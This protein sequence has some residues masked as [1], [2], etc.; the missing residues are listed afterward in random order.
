MDWKSNSLPTWGC[1]IV[2]VVAVILSI[3]WRLQDKGAAMTWTQYLPTFL[4]AA[5]LIV[6]GILHFIALRTSQADAG[7]QPSGQWKP[8]WQKLQWA[9]AERERLEGEVRKWK[10][11]YTAENIATKADTSL[12]ARTIAMCDE[13]HHFLKDHGPEPSP[14]RDPVESDTEYLVR[15]RAIKTPWQERLTADYKIK[16]SS[17][18]PRIRDEIRLHSGMSELGLDQAIERAESYYTNPEAV[19]DICKHLWRLAY[20]M[21]G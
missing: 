7:T 3:V 6:A 4:I 9:N 21:T 17:S 12:R 13:L 16:F 19:E 11:M 18:V 10:D 2:V 14:K 20:T 1:F 15:V 5:A 8:K